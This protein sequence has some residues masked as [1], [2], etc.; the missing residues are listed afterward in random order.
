M[1]LVKS[2]GF[3]SYSNYCE[4]YNDCQ[5]NLPRVSS[6]SSYLEHANT[7]SNEEYRMKENDSPNVILE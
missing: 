2:S 1:E 3:M 6:L 4:L 7:I 5:S